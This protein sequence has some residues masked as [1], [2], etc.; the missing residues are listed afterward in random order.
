MPASRTAMPVGTDRAGGSGW[1]RPGS[2]EGGGEEGR[3]PRRHGRFSLEPHEV[4]RVETRHRT[5]VAASG[6]G[7][8]RLRSLLRRAARHARAAAGPVGPRPGALRPRP[9]W[10][11]LDR[12]ELLRARRQ[13]GARAPARRRTRAE[14]HRPRPARHV[15]LR[16]RGASRAGSAARR[17][18]APGPDRAFLLTT[19]SR[20]SSL[21]KILRAWGSQGRA[22]RSSLLQGGFT[23]HA[24]LPLAVGIPALKT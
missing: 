19:G 21:L 10:K 2:G 23:A 6:A 15:R 3:P 7:S 14:A 4:P 16:A 22:R 5:I 13:R 20:R 9:L 1:M 24:R 17:A 8:A 12:L 11:P 18:R